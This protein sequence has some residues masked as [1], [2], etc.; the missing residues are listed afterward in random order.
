[1]S[2][3]HVLMWVKQFQNG[4]EDIIDK[5]PD[6]LT[7]Q[8]WR[9]WFWSKLWTWWRC[10]KMVPK[11][12]S[13]EQKMRIKEVCP[14]L[15]GKNVAKPY[16]G[17]EWLAIRLGSSIR[18][19]RNKMPKSRISGGGEQNKKK[20]KTNKPVMSKSKIKTMIIFLIS[21]DFFI[22]NLFLQNRHSIMNSLFKFWNIYS[23]ELIKKLQ[24][25]SQTSGFWMTMNLPTNHFW[26][27]KFQLQNKSKCWKT[28]HIHFI[29]PHVTFMFPKLKTSLQG[30]HL[31]MQLFRAVCWKYWKEFWK[32]ISKHGGSF[33]M[34][35]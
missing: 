2:R 10:V 30:S 27:I 26:Y 24:I 17:G 33:G 35:A 16:C 7:N 4:R 6:N 12:L 19:L 15:L 28:C 34:Y 5:R 21:K 11:I 22:I 1:M 20:K 3:T 14:D 31:E 9:D 23:S 32:M 29:W 13:T 25:F 18:W 8:K